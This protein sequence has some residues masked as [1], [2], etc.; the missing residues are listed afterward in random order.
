MLRHLS[1][2]SAAIALLRAKRRNLHAWGNA[3][4]GQ[5]GVALRA[6]D[7]E[8]ETYG[9]T[10]RSPREVT[11]IPDVADVS[12]AGAHTVFVS[13]ESGGVVYGSGLNDR[14]QLGVGPTGTQL[15]ERVPDVSSAVAAAAGGYHTLVLDSDGRVHSFGCNARGQL[16]RESSQEGVVV[17]S[18]VDAG[19]RIVSV[20]AGHDFSLALSDTGDV[21]TWGASDNGRLGHGEQ[22]GGFIARLARS[23][24]ADD[25]RRPRKV[26]ALAGEKITAI[27]AGSHSA[28]VLSSSGEFATFG[29]G[30]NFLLG[31]EKDADAWE[32]ERVTSV[33]ARG[34]KIALGVQHTLFLFEDGRLYGCGSGEHGA[35]GVDDEASQS[36]LSHIALPSDGPAIDVAAGWGVS[37]A[38]VKSGDLLAWGSGAALGNGYEE[39]DRWMPQKVPFPDCKVKHVRMAATGRHAFAW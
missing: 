9:F 19:V 35:L 32:P 30:R 34:V 14:G 16:G 18:L 15:P 6:S 13:R 36:E 33:P 1:R 4:L 37:L 3:D 20:A 38:V 10:V 31:N 25:E 27:F 23:R 21:Y 7:E 24:S 26:A 28:G 17:G 39:A 22:R 5:L 2:K 11:S 8:L 12:T 29:S